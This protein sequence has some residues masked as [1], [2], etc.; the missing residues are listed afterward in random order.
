M[1]AVGRAVYWP[2]SFTPTIRRG[3]VRA[4]PESRQPAGNPQVR[5]RR[6]AVPLALTTVRIL[7]PRLTAATRWPPLT[8]SVTR[9]G[10]L[11]VRVLGFVSFPAE[12]GCSSS[13][14]IT[15]KRTNARALGQPVPLIFRQC[16]GAGRPRDAAA[17]P[18]CSRL[19]STHECR[20]YR[21]RSCDGWETSS[22]VADSSRPHPA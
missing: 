8:G 6:G 15:R 22:C 20:I 13:A 18:G 21:D 2:L 5:G 14:A 1:T 7:C 12:A 16:H 17:L 4:F 10:L 9:A 19:L 3:T 11:S